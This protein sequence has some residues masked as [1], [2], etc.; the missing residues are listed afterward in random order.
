MSDTA[1]AIR[2]EPGGHLNQG[3]EH[4]PEM[5]RTTEVSAQKS[6]DSVVHLVSKTTVV[7]NTGA[8]GG[9]T[10]AFDKLADR[11]TELIASQAVAD[12]EFDLTT[13][14]STSSTAIGFIR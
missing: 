4:A 2:L 11:R 12:F 5:R 8:L 10:I 1:V 14:R 13:H 6:T 9:T 3:Q 7:D